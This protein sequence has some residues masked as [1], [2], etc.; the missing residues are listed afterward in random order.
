MSEPIT[1]FGGN[2][3]VGRHV[4]RLLQGQ[5]Q[6]ITVPARGKELYQSHLG[7]AIYCIGLTADFRSRPFD[8]AEAHVCLLQRLLTQCRYHSFTYLSSTR[9]YQGLSTTGT[10]GT[11]LRVCP[12]DPDHL[13]NLSKLMGESLVHA[14]AGRTHV[15]RLSNVYG[16]D[17]SSS[18]FLTSVIRAAVCDAHV[19][20]RSPGNITRDFVAVDDVAK[21]V[22]A[23]AL[24]GQS[25]SYN[26]AS[27]RSYRSDEVLAA[28]RAHTGCQVSCPVPDTDAGRFPQIDISRIQ[29][30]FSFQPR[31]LLDDLKDLIYTFRL[32]QTKKD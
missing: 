26:V 19:E 28:V 24:T 2:G 16:A 29:Q 6:A 32:H 12:E 15:V 18:N 25:A 8:T 30:E 1:V 22:G 3:F 13:Y 5:G 21:L 7:H 17:W 31:L 10:E 14:A 23:I 4:V 9:V 27:G 11:S 20:L